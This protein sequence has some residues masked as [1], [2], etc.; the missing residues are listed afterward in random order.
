MFAKPIVGIV[1]IAVAVEMLFSV[2]LVL[3]E[4]P[5]VLAK[6]PIVFVVLVVTPVIPIACKGGGRACDQH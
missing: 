3:A 5:I 2:P 4:M 1:S 6:V